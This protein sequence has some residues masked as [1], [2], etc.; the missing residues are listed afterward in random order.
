MTAGRDADSAA[1][2]VSFW[3]RSLRLRVLVLTLLFS[4][5]VMIALG[6]VLQQQI[7]DRLLAAKTSAAE[8][9]VRNAGAIVATQM[10]GNNPDRQVVQVNLQRAL[11]S[12]GTPSGDAASADQRSSAG[13]FQPVI[14]ALHTVGVAAGPVEQV[15]ADLQAHVARGILAEKNTSVNRGGNAVPALVVGMPVTTATGSFGVYLIFP[16]TSE[17]STAAVVQ[18]TLL[19][20]GAALTLA[21]TLI[22][23]LV[24][25]QV[26]R[27]VRRAAAV[28]QRF[29]AG[30]LDERMPVKGAI[31]LTTMARS[32]NG[33]AEAIRAQIR[34]LEQFGRLQRRF[35]SDVS[36]E[37]R[38]PVT[39]VRMA[40]DLL[41]SERATLPPHLARTSELLVA[42]VDRFET[43]LAD[44]L[45]ISRYDAGMADLNAEP[46]DI[47]T[48]VTAAIDGLA[49]LAAKAGV[50]IELRMPPTPVIAEVDSR[51]F[52][53]ILRN[54]LGN[55]I[56]HA[57]GGIVEVEVGIDDSAVAVSVTDHGVGL[58]PGESSLVFNRFWRADPS[59]Q[60]QTGGTGLGLAI[61][62]E[63]ARLHGGWLQ[64]SGVPGIGSRFRLT[65][66]QQSGALV[67]GSPLPLRVSSEP[68][69]AAQSD[70]DDDA[71]GDQRPGDPL[72]A[73]IAGLP[74]PATEPPRGPRR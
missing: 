5:A 33:M 53:R 60:R 66:P 57:E 35:T 56:D 72:I 68:E 36:H 54:L 40:A 42:E 26:V 67:T 71:A 20:G 52:E 45:E 61:S 70:G 3:G 22:A 44:L 2:P 28:A 63:D 59:R 37:L 29:A 16:L 24:A 41:Y 23:T 62:L 58:K 10:T 51:R 55:A 39:T 69:D 4:S 1:S 32:F 21:L 15:P 43:L 25:S 48:H 17:Q 50:T 18:T 6:L 49:S 12:I 30:A 7:V 47:R 27:P 34:Q 46:I 19:L 73:T 14:I 31:E 8:A 38:T 13:V 9:A 64:A 65:L 11:Q 74:V